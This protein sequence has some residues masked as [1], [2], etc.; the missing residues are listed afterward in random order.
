MMSNCMQK[1]QFAIRR[2]TMQMGQQFQGNNGLATNTQRYFLTQNTMMRSALMM[3][4]A[5]QNQVLMA[6]FLQRGFFT[7]N[8]NSYFML[9]SMN[10]QQILKQQQ[11]QQ[12]QSL[13]Q[14]SS[15]DFSIISRRV[16]KRTARVQKFKLKTKK[17]FAKRF[18]IGGKLR[19]RLFKF[20][21]LGYRHLNRNK[22]NRNLSRK[23]GRFLHHKAD[24]K[25]AQ[26]YMPYYKRRK[27]TKL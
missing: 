11:Q 8:K 10:T 19:D 5:Q 13:T 9:Q 24:I 16:A 26:K 7:L 18:V 21:A 20:H 1:L 3:R 2:Q 17:A 23:R 22:S 14:E 15:R 12:V 4:Q 6:N 27:Y 25:K